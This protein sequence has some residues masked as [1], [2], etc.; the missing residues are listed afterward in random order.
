[1][2]EL[3]DKKMLLNI[4]KSDGLSPQELLKLLLIPYCAH[5]KPLKLE[6]KLLKMVLSQHHSEKHLANLKLKK[7]GVVYIKVSDH[8][9]LDK[10]HIPL[11]NLSLLKPF[12]L[13]YMKKFLLKEKLTTPKDN[14]Y[15]LLSCQVILQ[16][17]SVPSYPTQ[18]I[19]WSLNY[20]PLKPEDLYYPTFKEF[21]LTSDSEDFGQD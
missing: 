21:M 9:G 4:R 6:C 3:L 20:I 7:D 12:L 8:F 18:L 2:Q 1:M 5:G 13:L 19:L 17:F 14:N 10:F 11:L 15:L 16:E